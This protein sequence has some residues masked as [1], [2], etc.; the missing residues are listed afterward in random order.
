[1]GSFM[2]RQYRLYIDESGDHSYG[3]KEL[4]RL[5]VMQ[6]QTSIADTS[7]GHYPELEQISKR[8][9]SLTGCIIKT[10]YYRSTFH[11]KFEELK[12][13]HFPHNPDEP[14]I[15]HRKEIIN[16]NGP[17]WRLRDPECQKS[18]ND[19]LL[20]YLEEMKYVLITAVIDKKTHIERYE[21]F[22]YH[23][24]HFCLAAM[25]ERYCGFLHFYNVHGDVMAESRGGTE[26][27]QLKDAYR[28]IYNS[29]T[30]FRKPD[31]FQKVLTS[32]EIK[33]KTKFVNI[34]GLQVADLFAY[35]LKQEILIEKG[36]CAAGSEI[37]GQSICDRVKDKHNR[38]QYSGKIY[39]YGKV[40]I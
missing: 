8:Y 14:V 34:A 37:F 21:D 27:R 10:E 18:F 9:L 6:E 20:R 13:K 19:S 1:M 12:Q 16:R 3:R 30:Q 36:I 11:P 40:F 25:L 15:L 33:L 26:D 7:I 29:G 31:F 35:P 24:Y 4:R 17:F 22:A 28:N 39:G 23:P 5:R 2:Q 32:K 38:H